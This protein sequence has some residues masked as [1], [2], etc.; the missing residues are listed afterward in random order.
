MRHE[1][2]A[3]RSELEA[4]VQAVRGLAAVER[5][6]ARIDELLEDLDRQLE[7]VQAA[8]VITLV[9]ATGAGKSTLLN[10]LV[11]HN[12]AVEGTS[13]PTTRAPVIYRP[14]DADLR[15][16]L[17]GLPGEAPEVVDYDPGGG[18]RW[19]GQILIDAPDVNSI[20]A[21]HR[22]VVAAL[23]ARSDVLVAV[24][25]RQSI[26]ELASVAFLD[27]FAGRRG[28]LFVLNRADEL[29]SAACEELLAQLRELAAER[30]GLPEAPVLAVSARD[31]RAGGDGT[32]WDELVEGLA[33]LARGGNLGRVRRHNALGSASALGEVFAELERGGLCADLDALQEA[34]ER[35]LERWQ[36]RLSNELDERLRLRRADLRA[37]LWN[38]V[39]RHW[40]GPGGWAL[41][42]GGLSAMGLGAG[43]MLVR[44]NPLLAAGAAV[45]ALAADRVREGLRERGVRDASGL[46]PPPGELESIHGVELGEARLAAARLTAPGSA[47][48]PDLL[49]VPDASALGTRA[50][51]A[52]DEAW[53]TLLERDLPAAAQAAASWPLRALV[54][55]PVIA[56]GGWVVWRAALGFFTEGA[57]LVGLDYLLNAV[58]VLMAWLFLA[59]TVVRA[60]LGARARAL[61]DGARRSAVQALAASSESARRRTAEALGSRRDPLARLAGLGERWRERLAGP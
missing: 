47:V 11:G 23:A 16:L 1:L 17:E 54:D 36:T 14:R 20:T 15:G 5:E 22:E 37:M 49:G 2:R 46:L 44:R 53:A 41:R 19:R 21:S 12:V 52:V 42:A 56:L 32:G 27:A 4:D 38:E 61:L 9:G 55:L 59:R 24:A 26:E 33:E 34:L 3:L 48:D 43:A 35:G 40:D 29:S 50:S 39:A 18:G 7:R 31:A 25:H 58:L 10:A 13:R 57:A 45:G 60:L 28:M 51:V 6:A 30:W 8:A